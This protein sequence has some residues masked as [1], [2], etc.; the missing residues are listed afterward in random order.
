MF[1]FKPARNPIVCGRI[2]LTSAPHILVEKFYLDQVPDLLPR[3]NISPNQDIAAV[4]PNPNSA[5]RIIRML[6]WGLLPPWSKERDKSPKLI[7]ARSE[8][9][10]QK[11]SFR[12]AFSQRRCL[13]PVNGFYEWQPRPGGNQPFLFHRKDNGLMALA[14]L[15]ERWEYPGGKSLE[16]CSILTTKANAM[17]RPIHHRMP[18]VLPEN[19]WK[20]WL[21]MPPEKANQLLE[22]LIPAPMGML[23]SHPVTRQVGNPAFDSPEALEPIWDDQGGQMNLFGA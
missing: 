12:E 19:D 22:L 20:I 6:Q 14:G 11:P 7:N 16:S 15:W 23:L 1:P 18:V 3:Y 9:V 13:I 10:M 4:M 21:E 2:L 5:G 17:M 8:T